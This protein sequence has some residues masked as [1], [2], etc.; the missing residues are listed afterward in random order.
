[1]A[2]GEVAGGLPVAG[3]DGLLASEFAGDAD[4]HAVIPVFVDRYVGT[5]GFEAIAHIRSEPAVLQRTVQDVAV[6]GTGFLWILIRPLKFDGPPPRRLVPP[7]DHNERGHP[8]LASL[9][10]RSFSLHGAR[11]NRSVAFRRTLGHPKAL[12]F[13]KRHPKRSVEACDSSHSGPGKSLP[14]GQVVAAGLRQALRQA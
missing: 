11:A 7:S 9:A 1:M 2:R 5:A 13:L 6:Q 10:K 14:R 3:P 12:D 8:R 4:A